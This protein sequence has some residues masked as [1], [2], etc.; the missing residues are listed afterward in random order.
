MSDLISRSALLVALEKSRKH[1]ANTNREDSLLCRCE[2]IVM[3]QPT[4]YDVEAV[5]GQLEDYR[6]EAQQFGVNGMLTDIIE[7]VRKGGVDH[8]EP[9]P[10]PQKPEPPWKQAFLRTFLGRG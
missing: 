9:E 4:A 7:V 5:V 8:A 3:E 6:E 2:N 10:E 1:H